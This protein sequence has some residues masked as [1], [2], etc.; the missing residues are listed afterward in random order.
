MKNQPSSAAYDIEL[1]S[2]YIFVKDIKR[3]TIF[4]EQIFNQQATGDS[5]T[6]YVGGGIR[7]WLFDYQSANDN[8]A[9]FGHNCLPSFKVNDIQSFIE[10]LKMLHAPIVYPLTRLG[11]SWVLEFKDTEG[12]D[13]E[14]WQP[15]KQ[16][17]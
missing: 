11:D 6:F 1:T 15:I 9:N 2:V 17:H 4:Y 12:N 3:A 13:I 14:V 10:K 8:R 5:P 16:E 7:F